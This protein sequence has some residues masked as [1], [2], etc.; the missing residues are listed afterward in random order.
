MTQRR[1]TLWLGV[2]TLLIAVLIIGLVVGSGG[3][4][5]AF[6]RP[7]SEAHRVA[8][9]NDSA[10][11]PTPTTPP[12][13]T[14]TGTPTPTIMPTATY[15]PT[16][17]QAPTFT[18]TASP[19]NTL[20]GT[21]APTIMPTATYTLTPTRAPTFTPIKDIAP[22]FPLGL[23][24]V[25][26]E[27]FP[28]VREAGFEFVHIYDSGQSL[29]DAVHYLTA[30]EEAGLQ[31]MQN[32]PSAHLRDGD[33][34]WI[35]WVS[36]LAAYDNLTWWY[37]PEEP[38]STDHETM[39][40]LYEIVREYDPKGRPAVVYFGTT[41]LARWCDISDIMLLPAY[42]EYHG[43]PRAVARAWLD[44]AREACP[45]K[46]V[47]SVQTLFD[48]NFDGTGDRPTP[49]EARSDAYT[50][51]IAGSQGLAWYSYVRGKDLP[52]LWP[53]VQEVAEEIKTLAPVIASPL[54]SQTVHAQV[55]SGPTHSPGFEGHTYD[56]IQ[57]LQKTHA[58]VTYIMA[59]NLAEAPVTVQFEG[60]SERT[61][62]VSVLFEERTLPI[63]NGVFC[64]EFSPAAVHIYV[65]EH[66]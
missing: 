46:T 50:A 42:P 31:V 33:E 19:T 21:P 54:I 27:E 60:L 3:A 14:L 59:V 10:A 45:A 15:T 48:T 32:M 17:T 35:E 2:I 28:A 16:P 41:H 22:G 8:N 9:M 57:V 30:A 44:I 4:L 23:Y 6:T 52:D 51:I 65:T 43:A 53:A 64:D 38:R 34:F 26:L 18:P 7:D 1:L 20:T 47:V 58:G 29:A 66:R 39:R 11:S 55:L 49:V 40:R 62:E 24:D 13:N 25:P 37:L 61:T 12:T 36:T 56:S 5:F 63:E